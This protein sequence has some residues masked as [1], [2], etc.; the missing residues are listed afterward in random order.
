MW[1]FVVMISTLNQVIESA[2]STALPAHVVQIVA[3]DSYQ[4]VIKSDIRI[5]AFI[6]SDVTQMS[7]NR[8]LAES[9]RCYYA[10]SG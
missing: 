6:G 8:L 10:F 7:I 5:T 4:E 1:L 9:R 2:I 3:Y